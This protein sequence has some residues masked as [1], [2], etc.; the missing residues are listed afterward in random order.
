MTYVV[1]DDEIVAEGLHFC[2]FDFHNLECGHVVPMKAQ[3]RPYYQRLKGWHP[4]PRQVIGILLILGGIL[5]FL[6]ILGFW[7]IPLGLLLLSHDYRWARKLFVQIQLLFR[8]MRQ[9]MRRRRAERSGS[10]P[11]E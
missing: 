11:S 10:T 7:M 6:P 2:E 4:L 1:Y 3:L 8:Q 9:R 5:G